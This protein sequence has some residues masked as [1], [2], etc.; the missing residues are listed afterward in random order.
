MSFSSLSKTNP[1]TPGYIGWGG[2]HLDV[3]GMGQ[4]LGAGSAD[5]E[6]PSESDAEIIF[7]DVI[8]AVLRAKISPAAS[9]L[10]QTKLSGLTGTFDQFK[11]SLFCSIVSFFC[12]RLNPF[13]NTWCSLV[14]PRFP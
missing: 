2:F 4:A 13:L 11:P 12:H 1:S 7:R 10:R 9:I 8:Q 14:P 3:L 6:T 5:L